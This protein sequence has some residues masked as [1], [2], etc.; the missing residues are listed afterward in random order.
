VF[1]K[2]VEVVNPCVYSWLYIPHPL[3]T[4]SDL[5][6]FSFPLEGS[7]RSG[8]LSPLYASQ[9]TSVQWLECS[10]HFSE[11]GMRHCTSPASLPLQRQ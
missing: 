8:Q 1:C 3:P 9:C 4:T 10:T 2:A 11:H 6:H 7:Q 5:K